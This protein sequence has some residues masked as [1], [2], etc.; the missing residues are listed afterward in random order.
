MAAANSS[1]PVP[2]LFNFRAQEIQGA[3]KQVIDKLIPAHL[4]DA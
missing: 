2:A 4:C 3:S 1:E